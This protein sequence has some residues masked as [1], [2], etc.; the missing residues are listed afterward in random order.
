MTDAST[1]SDTGHE[2]ENARLLVPLALLALYVVWGSTYL[3]IR[4][5]LESWP[6]FMLAAIRFVFAGTLM[7]GWLR[8][9]GHA[10][11]S[12]LQW[13]NAA[14]TGVLLL[15][16]G[17]GLVCYA[18]Q[19]VSSGI[20]AVAVAS[21]P[22]FAGLFGGLMGEWPRRREIIG[23][24][25]GFSGVI[26]LN[27]GSTL[28]GSRLGALALLLAAASW[29]F[30]SQWSRRQD[31]PKGPMNTAAQMLCGGAVPSE[32]RASSAGHQL[33]LRQSAGSGAVWCVTGWRNGR[34]H[35][36]HR[37]GRDTGWRDHCC[38]EAPPQTRHRSASGV[39]SLWRKWSLRRHP[40]P[41]GPLGVYRRASQWLANHASSP[42]ALPARGG[43]QGSASPRV[44]TRAGRWSPAGARHVRPGTGR[45]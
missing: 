26:L 25:V 2:G 14:I 23:L 36:F 38:G 6:P 9:R 3:G 34:A 13:R 35:R 7:Y 32:S 5:A 40:G 28:S 10:A 29:A 44:R 12:R 45:R 20:A 43:G 21:M 11:P 39:T 22:L 18:E 37:H 30:G 4:F 33:C 1:G 8:W 42:P 27:L 24:V 15:M 19:S 16:L 41:S 17:N 31:M